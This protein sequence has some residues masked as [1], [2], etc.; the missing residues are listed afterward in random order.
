MS[1]DEDHPAPP[2]LR[3]EELCGAVVE[4]GGLLRRARPLESLAGV[5]LVV[6]AGQ[7]LAI[8]GDRA[9]GRRLLGRMLAGTA[10]PTSGRVLLSGVDVTHAGA[11]RPGE[12][13]MLLGPEAPGF[14]RRR[15]VRALLVEALG[16]GRQRAGVDAP[17]A[18]SGGASGGGGAGDGGAAAAFQVA[19]FRAPGPEARWTWRRWLP[20]W[21]WT[22]RSSTAQLPLS[23]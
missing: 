10:Q 15:R 23:A 14:P 2:L 5:D 17:D 7:T 13:V 4:S 9:C 3:A 19:A 6:P 18:G 8:V 21:T 16:A 1:T 20:R 22:W 12:R 11:L